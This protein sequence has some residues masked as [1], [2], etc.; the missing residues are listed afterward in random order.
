MISTRLDPWLRALGY[1]EASPSLHLARDPVPQDHPYAPEL[2]DLLNP[3]GE[4]QAQAVFDVDGVPAIT[5]F[6]GGEASPL[7]D[8]AQLL[9]LRQRIWNQ[10]LITV[11]L[12][13]DLDMATAYPA[14]AV[15]GA[16]AKLKLADAKVNGPWSCS[17]LLSG[18][19]RERFPTWFR[20]E[21]RVD[22][23]LLRNLN[24]TVRD[25]ATC[26]LR[27]GRECGK[28]AAQY[29]VGQALFISYLE[30][31]GIVDEPYRSKNKVG[32]FVDLVTGRDRDGLAQL[33]SSLKDDFNGDF[34]EPD[35]KKKSLWLDL[36][37]AGFDVIADFL[38]A[39]D[40]ANAQPSLFPYNFRYIPV[41]L[42][43]GI[44]ESFL[45]DRKK[46]L[47]A[48]YTPRHLANVVV[49]QALTNSTDLLAERIYDGA[50]GSGILLTTAFRRL[51]GAAEAKAQRQLSLRDRIELLQTQI[52]GSDLSEAA[53]RVTAFSLYLSLLEQLQ[54]TD[55]VALCEDENVKLP[56]LRDFNLFCGPDKG[57]FFSAQNPLA[58]ERKFTL[59]LS[60]P[61]WSEPDGESTGLADEWAAEQGYPRP[62]R[63][64]AAD[65]VWRARECLVP[66][67]RMCVI[68]PMTLLLKPT[69]Q[70]FLSAW[71]T[72]VRWLRLINF[73][74]LKELLFDEGRAS[75]IV[76][77]ASPR[78]L[79]EHDEWIVPP[80]EKFEYWVPKADVGLAFGR[81][82]LHGVDRHQVQTQAIV[83]SNRELV[84]RMWGDEFDMALWARL[85]LRGTF[86]DLLRGKHK[87]WSRRKGFH[88]VD[89]YVEVEKHVS[90]APLWKMKFLRPEHLYRCPVIADA[91]LD[92]FP[93]DEMPT[94]PSLD[95][96]LIEFFSGPR[97]LFPDGPAP[98]RSIRAAFLA[99]PAS[100]MSSV[101]VIGGPPED[102][103]LL[104]FAAFYLRSDLVRYLM[105]TQVY[106]LLS[107]RDRV[108]LKDIEQFPFYP[109]E[110][111]ADPAKARR[112]VGKVAA[113]S[114][115][116][117][118]RDDFTRPRA[119]EKMRAKV[120]KYIKDYFDLPHDAQAIVKETVDVILPAT[121]PYGMSRVYELAMERVS[122]AVA[123][124]YADALQNEL[125]A[126][127]DAGDGEGSFD[128]NVYYTDERHTGALAVA[129]VNLHKK[130]ES[131]PT[132]QQA[133]LVVDAILRKLK[134]A[135]LL[136]VELQER[137]HFVPDTLIVSGNTA[138]LIKPVAQRLWLRRQ[139]RR[140]AARIVSATTGNC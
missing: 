140:D 47:A 114:R 38:R 3:N 109:P 126:W 100:F 110:R 9:Q 60:N 98:D 35:A 68:L 132:G 22:R 1:A 90:S 46:E 135:Q 82:S 137:M 66:E 13:A 115:W 42:L 92:A 58:N 83:R 87:R 129:Q 84:T 49:S 113:I 134:E 72:Q 37:N 15:A 14:S 11:V 111:H 50:C 8:P 29:L 101:G 103:D 80:T 131:K 43:S 45:G 26:K 136:T 139:A 124:H 27:N 117:E 116:L 71:L 81:I 61:P 77:L 36:G 91:D 76:L 122:D 56:P 33:L 40:V 55:I 63:Q 28:S 127:R 123:E 53:C 30:H 51:I 65:F 16:Q 105:V 93:R 5:F 102:E 59:F 44:Y 94:L 17:D 24:L 138:Y 75:C 6:V 85:R 64:I 70:E 41:E 2:R 89:S 52:F 99:T 25:L 106:Q 119:W 86:G 74:D 130:A 62:L 31:R 69:S 20:L 78:I 97:I 54:P 118:Q 23:K 21:D 34:L 108:S 19:V 4:I 133:N 67:G 88:R 128:V 112:I 12:V 79:S 107:D 125:N 104:R 96:S 73:G 32:T 39:T 18:D 57:D 7:Q 10:G 95:A 121:R 48:Y 120:E